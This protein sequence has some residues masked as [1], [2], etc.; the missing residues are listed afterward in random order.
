MDERTIAKYPFLEGSRE[1]VKGLGI[2]MDSIASEEFRATQDRAR[3]RIVAAIEGTEEIRI[4]DPDLRST[5]LSY[6][7]AR[8][9]VSSIADRNLIKWF[10]HREAENAASHLQ[11]ED[12]DLVLSIGAEVGLGVQDPP[13]EG[14]A[15]SARIVPRVVK[16]VR[17]RGEDRFEP[18]R[19]S[20]WVR[21]TDYLPARSLISGAE[22]DLS[23]QR[24]VAGMIELNRK[25][26][27][28][29]LQERIKIRVEAGLDQGGALPDTGR[30]AEI[31]KEIRTRVETRRKEYQPASVGKVTITRMPPCMR[32]LLGMSQAG[33]NMP[34]HAR[35][36]L[37]TFL[38]SIGMGPEEIFRT[39]TASPDFK[40]DIVRY[41]IEH[42][43]GQS[44]GTEYRVPGCDTMKSGG[45]CYMPDRFCD[46]EWMNSPY[47][48]Y[49][50]KGRRRH[51]TSEGSTS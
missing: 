34:H 5:I 40:E 51:T 25:R 41:Q 20:Y 29:L 47:I 38:H 15:S 42:I 7:L 14:K 13:V 37:V 10:S 31:G 27:I 24:L 16:G 1:Y 46:F 26:Y 18:E 19:R 11:E 28:R 43:T 32:Q 36:A 45:I 6:P 21:L 17:P 9:L 22:W 39:F 4:I 23:N 48:Y 3:D 30:L 44:S 49:R 12:N 8:Y 35:F 50:A 2:Q 33:E